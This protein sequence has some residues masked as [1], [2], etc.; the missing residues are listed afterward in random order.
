MSTHAAWVAFFDAQE[1]RLQV[2]RSAHTFDKV[3]EKILGL[4]AESHR[5][6]A[7]SWRDKNT[8]DDG[9]DKDNNGS[10]GKLELLRDDTSTMT[11]SEDT[12]HD[13]IPW[14][15]RVHPRLSTGPP[16]FISHTSYSLSSMS[17]TEMYAEYSVERLND[18]SPDATSS[19]RHEKNVDKSPKVFRKTPIAPRAPPVSDSG[20]TSSSEQ[21]CAAARHSLNTRCESKAPWRDIMR[22]QRL[23]YNKKQSE[24]TPCPVGALRRS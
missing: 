21:Q 1:A 16:A 12:E 19:S 5:L 24:P 7:C 11:G 13:S 18:M 8:D 4:L 9:E 15:D 22:Q 14:Q 2:F 23:Q 20:K 10:S 3:Q 17:A 6:S